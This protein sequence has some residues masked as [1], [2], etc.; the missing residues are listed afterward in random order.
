MAKPSSPS[1]PHS[2]ANGHHVDLNGVGGKIHVPITNPTQHLGA[3][4]VGN[5]AAA[6]ARAAK[7][8]K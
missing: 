1:P 7:G 8:R 6:A 4:A 3:V 2:S 5:A